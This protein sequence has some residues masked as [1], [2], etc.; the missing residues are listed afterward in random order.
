MQYTRT[1]FSTGST[2]SIVNFCG[3]YITGVTR[4]IVEIVFITA[5]QLLVYGISQLPM[6]SLKLGACPLTLPQEGLC[7]FSI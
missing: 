4:H 2:L 1:Q 3:L 6:Q 5:H 7:S